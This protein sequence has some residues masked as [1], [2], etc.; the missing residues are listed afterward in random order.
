[1]VLAMARSVSVSFLSR[2]EVEYNFWQY[3]QAGDL[4]GNMVL[5][6]NSRDKRLEIKF[7]GPMAKF[8][9]TSKQLDAYRHCKSVTILLRDTDV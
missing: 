1:M 6:N 4:Y 3:D 9:A 2:S 5:H 8:S 7:V